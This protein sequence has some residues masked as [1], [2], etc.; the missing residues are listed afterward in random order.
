MSGVLESVEYIELD[1]L[2]KTSCIL[3]VEVF[4][5]NFTVLRDSRRAPVIAVNSL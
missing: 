1:F 4:K 5:N 3:E 2:A